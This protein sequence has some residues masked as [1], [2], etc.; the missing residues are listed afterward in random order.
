MA[1]PGSQYRPRDRSRSPI[2]VADEGLQPERTAMSWTRTSLAMMVCSLT[3]LRWSQPY[4]ALVFGAIGLLFL[5]SL[6]II[7]RNRADYR[8]EAEGLSREH[9]DANVVGVAA[10]TISMTVLGGL[11][12]YLVVST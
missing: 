1:A 12:L 4:S 8:A 9:V 2:P 11:G 6:L 5:L 7:I 10:I 3:L